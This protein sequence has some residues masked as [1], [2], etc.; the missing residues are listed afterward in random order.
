[1]GLFDK[2]T[3][4]VKV[5]QQLDDGAALSSPEAF[6]AIALAAVASDGYL[7][8]EEAQSIPFILSHMQLF[9]AYSDD[10]MRRLFDKLLARLQHSGVEA[11]VVSAKDSLEPDLRETAFTVAT[12][13]VLADGVV[14]EEEETFLQ[15]LQGKLG[16]DSDLAQQVV[17]VMTIKN[18]G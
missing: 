7:S 10:M 1:M 13:L 18:R 9:K 5:T 17:R 8:E 16:I 11:L 12:D 3:K 6:A 2:V 14:T 15:D 4:Q